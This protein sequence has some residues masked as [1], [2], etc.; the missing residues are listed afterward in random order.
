MS[1]TA[2]ALLQMVTMTSYAFDNLTP[3][4]KLIYDHDHLTQTDAGQVLNYRYT[5][6]GEEFDSVDDA[7]KAIIKNK[8]DDHKRD[9]RIDF[10]SGEHQMI[11]PEF[12]GYRGNPV[13][14]AMLEYS[15][16]FIS[17][18]TG[19][20]TLYVRNRIR[21]GLAGEISI[22]SGEAELAG[23]PIEIQA[24]SFQPFEADANLSTVKQFQKLVYRI[25]LSENVPGGVLEIQ[26]QSKD[27][28]GK[29]L[30]SSLLSFKNV[31]DADKD[32]A[33]NN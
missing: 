18:E 22:E 21:D 25:V 9:V 1:L 14:I 10:L 15:A 5:L 32:S 6:V 2:G 26:L 31:S 3:A 16:Q 27:E 12:T 24:L 7:V 4:Q 11:L 28:N 17:R 23:K 19:G 33:T 13:I 30:L 8:V 29:V 20:G